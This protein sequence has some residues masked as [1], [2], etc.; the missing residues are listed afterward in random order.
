MDLN[1]TSTRATGNNG[2]GKTLRELLKETAVQAV[3]EMIR[4]VVAVRKPAVIVSIQK[5][6]WSASGST[7]TAGYF[8][9]LTAGPFETEEE[10]IG[11]FRDLAEHHDEIA[12]ETQSLQ[13]RWDRNHKVESQTDSEN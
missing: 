7:L 1:I 10:A 3:E 6:E 4:R 13:D 2:E 9:Q 5:P 12:R 11:V 8:V